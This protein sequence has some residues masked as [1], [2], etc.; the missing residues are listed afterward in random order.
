MSTTH[1]AQRMETVQ[2]NAIAELLKFVADPELI[3]FAGCHPDGSLF[4][5]AQLNEV[6]QIAI[7]QKGAQAL[8]NSISDGDPKSRA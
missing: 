3:S 6:Y 1:F 5:L 4:P 8:Q 7:L 2:P